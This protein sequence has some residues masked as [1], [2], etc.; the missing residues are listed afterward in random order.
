MAVSG[1]L[2][3]EAAVLGAGRIAVNVISDLFKGTLISW[4][5]RDQGF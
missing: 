4:V 2:H 5:I 3:D 1:I